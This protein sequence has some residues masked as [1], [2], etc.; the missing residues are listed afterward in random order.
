MESPAT[1]FGGNRPI[2]SRHQ[3]TRTGGLPGRDILPHCAQLH[4]RHGLRYN[5]NLYTQCV[6]QRRRIA[7]GISMPW[8]Q[9]PV[10][11][12]QAVVQQ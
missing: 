9:Q 12:Y 8:Q 6:T 1:E 4:S 5:D 3:H 7:A 11:V 2:P 10:A